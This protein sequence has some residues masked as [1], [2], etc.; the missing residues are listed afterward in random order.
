MNVKGVVISEDS[1]NLV[2]FSKMNQISVS[3]LFSLSKAVDGL[4][5]KNCGFKLFSTWYSQFGKSHEL[6]SHFI[7][8]YLV[9]LL[10]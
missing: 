4:G 7:R 5:T 3:Q 8:L 1:F 10:P 2:L 6:I 9:P